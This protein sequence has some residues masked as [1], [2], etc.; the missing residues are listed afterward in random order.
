MTRMPLVRTMLALVCLLSTGWVAAQMLSAR[1]GA[2]PF[3]LEV[4]DDPDSRRQGLMG[5]T[6][7][8]ANKGMLFDFPEG[9]TPSIWMRNM[10]MPLDLIYLDG[11]ARITHLFE[12]VPPCQALPCEI[13]RADRPLRFVIEVPAGTVDRLDLTLGQQVD[14]GG[15][16]KQPQPQN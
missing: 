12:S 8:G 2:E 14:L 10:H 16:E 5:R 13:Y 3:K 6:E 1:L 4:V 11:D 9:V 7:L 15:L